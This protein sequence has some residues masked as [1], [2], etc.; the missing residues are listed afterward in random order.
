MESTGDYYE[1]TFT[2][3]EDIDHDEVIAY[4]AGDFDWFMR[5]TAHL[6]YTGKLEVELLDGGDIWT[7]PYVARRWTTGQ[8]PLWW[9]RLAQGGT[10]LPGDSC[11]Q[12]P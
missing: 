8:S 4:S 11:S 2:Y 12:C 1:S 10:A 9:Q 7:G 3:D 5:Y 6:G